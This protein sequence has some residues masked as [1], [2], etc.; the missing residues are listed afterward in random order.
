MMLYNFA[1]LYQG[2]TNFF[3]GTRLFGTQFY[4][5]DRSGTYKMSA[6][7]QSVRTIEIQLETLIFVLYYLNNA[8]SFHFKC[9]SIKKFFC[10]ETF[11]VGMLLQCLK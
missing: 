3:L 7:N 1:I 9:A 2:W 4:L 5:R 10:N 8:C 6:Q 11:V